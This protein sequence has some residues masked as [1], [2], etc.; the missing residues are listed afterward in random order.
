MIQKIRAGIRGNGA[1]IPNDHVAVAVSG[2][3]SSS[4]LCHVA[5]RMQTDRMET[6]GKDK[7][8]FTM[9][10]IHVI[11][12]F[13]EAENDLTSIFDQ[14]IER[15][16]LE[17]V[18][19][20]D[21]NCTED[22]KRRLFALL[23][24]VSDVTGRQ[25]LLEYLQRRVLL[26]TAVRLGCSKLLLGHNALNMSVRNVAATVKGRGY[27]LPGDFTHIDARHVSRGGPAL[28]YP[29]KDV[30]QEEIDSLTSRLRLISSD[31]T[32]EEGRTSLPRDKSN[33]NSL[34]MDFIKGVQGHNPGVT[35]NINS[36][37][38]KLRNFSWNDGD[39]EYP[40][41]LCPLCYAPLA[42]DELLNLTSPSNYQLTSYACDSCRNQIF[43][44]HAFTVTLLPSAIQTGMSQL[45]SASALT[46]DEYGGE[47]MSCTTAHTVR[48]RL[49]QHLNGQ[50]EA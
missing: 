49:S 25:D 1:V 5:K 48:A 35:Y 28:V 14:A 12:P 43:S 15:V 16:P 24:S 33:I 50:V 41:I 46:C 7:I 29:L 40:E 45:Q 6:R 31:G 36:T 37:V 47:V 4:L 8:P 19:I 18:Y 44:D 20:D 39:T 34:A 11:N 30:S 21:E 27:A 23:E 32:G 3:P 10:L 38:S 22:R 13:V 2:G 9:V 26:D 17:D 42:D